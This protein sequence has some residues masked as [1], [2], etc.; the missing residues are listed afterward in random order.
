MAYDEGLA[1]RMREALESQPRL[2]EKRMFGGLAF[3]VDGHMAAGILGE[4]LM[5]RV[6]PERAE[7]ALAQ[8]HVRP[9]DFTGKPMK[10]YLY[11]EPAG[12]E[13]D[14]ALA[15]WLDDCIAFVTTLSRRAPKG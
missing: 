2:A 11:V 1:Q 12:I 15:A 9:M 7:A 4:T 6:G 13:S 3:M 14:E 5:A 8:P 10:G